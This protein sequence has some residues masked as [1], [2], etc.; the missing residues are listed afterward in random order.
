VVADAFRFAPVLLTPTWPVLLEFSELPCVG[1]LPEIVVLAPAPVGV[2]AAAP[3]R[4]GAAAVVPTTWRGDLGMRL[5]HATRAC[6][7]GMRLGRATRAADAF[8]TVSPKRSSL[9]KFSSPHLL[10]VTAA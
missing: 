4:R 6:D 7:L 2:P 10:T 9:L 5:G 3:I 8:A 1:G